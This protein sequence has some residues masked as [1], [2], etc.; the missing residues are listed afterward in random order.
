MEPAWISGAE[1]AQKCFTA[2]S[3]AQGLKT[4]G[5]DEVM[6]NDFLPVQA[7][8]SIGATMA[9]I[10]SKL[11]AGVRK[12][13]DHRRVTVRSSI[14]PS[15]LPTRG[16]GK[17]KAWPRLICFVSGIAFYRFEDHRIFWVGGAHR[18]FHGAPNA[19]HPF[20][21]GGLDEI[22]EQS[23]RGCVDLVKKGGE[24]VRQGGDDPRPGFL[25]SRTAYHHDG[26]EP[27]NPRAYV[28][29]STVEYLAVPLRLMT[30]WGALHGLPDILGCRALVWDLGRQYYAEVPVVGV[31]TQ[32]VGL[33]AALWTRFALA[34]D[35][36]S[37]NILCELFPGNPMEGYRL[38]PWTPAT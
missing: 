31:D 17:K 16:A 9:E 25:V 33:S 21:K 22:E 13:P 26:F 6:S 27:E 18:V 7:D 15:K 20:N 28:D 19:Y 23:N 37:T 34:K 30:A 35:S 14:L 11:P 1:N 8:P 24:L 36:T 5:R 38:Q 2:C 32:G 12:G 29:A 3:T 10:R 4:H